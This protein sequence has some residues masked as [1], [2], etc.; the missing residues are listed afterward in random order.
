MNDRDG[1]PDIT[2]RP[3]DSPLSPKVNNARAARP[4]RVPDFFRLERPTPS[5]SGLASPET[6]EDTFSQSKTF[7]QAVSI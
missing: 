4:L 2:S 3:T 5:S 1:T 6:V 7:A